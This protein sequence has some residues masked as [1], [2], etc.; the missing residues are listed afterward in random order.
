[1]K[2]EEMVVMPADV[3]EMVKMK[4]KKKKEKKKEIVG[5]DD[6]ESTKKV[7][8]LV[9]EL[10]VYITQAIKRGFNTSDIFYFM[11]VMNQI[12][13]IVR[14]AKMILPELKDLDKKE[15]Q[16]LAGMLYDYVKE[17]IDLATEE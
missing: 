11:Q 1:M 15:A 14:E 8:K 16:D 2:E 3:E 9:G 12:S 17:I 10:S 13:D 6:I 4:R 7:I 5:K